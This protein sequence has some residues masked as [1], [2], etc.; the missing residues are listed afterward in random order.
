MV[1]SILIFLDLAVLEYE[2]RVSLLNEMTNALII[3][4]P[5]KDDHS[6]KYPT[7]N[8]LDGP[9]LVTWLEA[10]KICIEVGARY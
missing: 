5:K 3:D 1:Y 2:R 10:R 7:L 4:F 9:S 6:I 8:I